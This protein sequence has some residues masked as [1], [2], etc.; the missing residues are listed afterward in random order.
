[1]SGENPFHIS[2]SVKSG[3]GAISTSPASEAR[4]AAIRAMAAGVDWQR[5]LRVVARQRVRG[6]AYAALKSA[7]VAPPAE[8][9]AQ[10]AGSA[11][12]AAARAMSLAA[13][14]IRLRTLFEAERLPVLFV[15]GAS[16]AQLAPRSRHAQLPASHEP[17]Q[18]SAAWVQVPAVKEQAQVPAWQVWAVR[19]GLAEQEVPLA[20]GVCTQAP[21]TTVSV[22]QGLPSSQ[23]GVTHCAWPP[24]TWQAWFCVA[25]GLGRQG[26]VVQ[27]PVPSSW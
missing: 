19:Q 24:T 21:C 4:D 6:L 25:Q 10:L 2:S 15:K 27:V 20:T 1:M 11:Q 3:A 9:E 7:R 18:Q 16:L 5:F 23:L 14:A 13:E 22:V 8:I 17:E 26:L 12:A